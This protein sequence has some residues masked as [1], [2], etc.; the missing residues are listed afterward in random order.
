MKLNNNMLNKLRGL[1]DEALWREIRTM[2]SSYGLKL[3]EKTPNAGDLKKVRDA[4][5]IGEI[6][7]ADAMRLMNEYKRRQ[8]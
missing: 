3:P 1:D 8:G 4:L 6:S 5:D 2:A 7:T